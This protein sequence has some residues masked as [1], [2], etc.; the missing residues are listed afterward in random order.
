[1]KFGPPY[2]PMV[3]ASRSSEARDVRLSLAIVGCGGEL[4][5]DLRVNGGRPKAP[6]FQIISPSGEI[7]LRGKFEF[8]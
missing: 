1:M 6:S 2:K 7:I 5:D 3:K 4:V 8:G